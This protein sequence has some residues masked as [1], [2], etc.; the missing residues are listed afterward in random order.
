MAKPYSLDLRKRVVAA[1][2]GGM[3]RHHPGAVASSLGEK[4]LLLQHSSPQCGFRATANSVDRG[5]YR[6]SF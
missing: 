3:S 6:E 4:W 1:L 5:S 2:E